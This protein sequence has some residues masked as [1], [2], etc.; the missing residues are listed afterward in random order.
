MLSGVTG[1]YAVVI[2]IIGILQCVKA[3]ISRVVFTHPLNNLELNGKLRGTHRFGTFPV[4]AGEWRVLVF[5]FT[6]LQTRDTFS[7][8]SVSYW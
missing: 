5:F 6:C 2:C 7:G 3:A 4:G 1:V 8:P